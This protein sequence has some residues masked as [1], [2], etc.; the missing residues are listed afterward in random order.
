MY[1]VLILALILLA[2]L[3]ACSV[4]DILGGIRAIA[5]AIPPILDTAIPALETRIPQIA[6]QLPYILGTPGPT[7]PEAGD[8]AYLS[9][10]CNCK[11]T[12]GVDQPVLLRWGWEAA[13]RE[14]AEAN[15]QAMTIELQVDGQAVPQTDSYRQEA[16]PSVTGYW[17][18]VWEVPVGR[19]PLGTHRV[20][21]RATTAE[22]I[23][24]GFDTDGDSQ[25]DTYG[26][27]EIFLGWVEI[28][29]VAR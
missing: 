26:P 22:T 25:A 12:V 28:E 4:E 20:E 19:L 11:V 24:D 29:L 16:Q 10:V 14:Q 2:L 23:S 18:V 13:T 1:R 9:P 27:G 21:I 3:S 7:T 5:T 8:T 15:A 17:V 6:T